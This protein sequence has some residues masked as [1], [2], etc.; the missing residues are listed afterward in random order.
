MNNSIKYIIGIL[1][2]IAMGFFIGRYT[3]QIKTITIKDS[4]FVPTYSVEIDTVKIKPDIEKLWKEAKAYWDK[5][6]RPVEIK[7]IHDTVTGKTDTVYIPQNINYVAELDTTYSD[8]SLAI[9]IKFIS[10]I[11]LY[12]ESY[13]NV[14]I[15]QKRKLALTEDG[16]FKNRFVFYGGVG[17]SSN[18]LL[19]PSW[20]VGFGIALYRF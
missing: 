12:P 8:K 11:P 7:T 19:N 14:D 15:R 4:V 18:N 1:V 2:L 10:K 5:K 20:Q 3:T 16:W 9:K 13:F 6:P 17:L